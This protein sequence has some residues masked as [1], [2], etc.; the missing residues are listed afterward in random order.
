MNLIYESWSESQKP[1][2]LISYNAIY[3]MNQNTQGVK[4]QVFTLGG[5][6][7]DAIGRDYEEGFRDPENVPHVP[8]AHYLEKFIL[9]R[10]CHSFV[11]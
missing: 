8:S 10:F 9:G 5:G 6:V 2:K 7:G 11:C 4:S 3:I 1:K